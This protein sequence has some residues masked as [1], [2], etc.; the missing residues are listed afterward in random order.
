MVV[1]GA[2]DLAAATTCT[3]A[4]TEAFCP[5][6]QMFTAKFVLSEQ[7]GIVAGIDLGVERKKS[8]W[9]GWPLLH[10]FTSSR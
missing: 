10:D 2:V 4:S 1:I 6:E 8:L 9:K 7:G 3:G 5:G